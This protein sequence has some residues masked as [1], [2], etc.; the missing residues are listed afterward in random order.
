MV[1][2]GLKFSN[3]SC[4]YVTVGEMLVQ[5]SKDLGIYDLE[6]RNAINQLLH[7]LCCAHVCVKKEWGY[8]SLQHPL[9]C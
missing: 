1:N 7:I 9:E 3:G 8:S 4:Q 5:D 6:C 2:G